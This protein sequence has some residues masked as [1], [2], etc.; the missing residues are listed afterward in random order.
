MLHAMTPFRRLLAAARALAVSGALLAFATGCPLDEG[1][2]ALSIDLEVAPAE[3]E[4]DPLFGGSPVLLSLTVSNDGGAPARLTRAEVVDRSGPAISLTVSPVANTVPARGSLEVRVTAL[5]PF[6]G[7]GLFT[8]SIALEFDDSITI[9]VPVVALVRVAPSCDDD[10]PCTE[11]SFDGTACRHVLSVDGTPCDDENACTTATFCFGGSCV[12]E[13]VRCTDGQ[14]CTVDAC[15]PTQGCV[16]EPMHERCD[17][18]DPCTDDVCASDTGCSNSPKAPGSLCFFGGCEEVGLC[19]N[20][21]CVMHDV[22]NGFPCSDGDACTIDDTCQEGVCAPGIAAEPGPEDPLVLVDGLVPAT[23]CAGACTTHHLEPKEVLAAHRR[24]DGTAQVVWR[25]PYVMSDTGLLCD[26]FAP[27]SLSARFI[28]PDEDDEGEGAAPVPC[29]CASDADCASGHCVGGETGCGG[30]EDDAAE[31]P[32]DPAPPSPPTCQAAIFLSRTMGQSVLTTQLET[33]RGPVAASLLDTNSIGTQVVVVTTAGPSS[34]KGTFYTGSGASLG[35]T[36]LERAMPSWGSAWPIGRLA[37]DH[38]PTRL[39]VVATPLYRDAWS[40]T[41]GCDDLGL[42]LGVPV[43]IW[44][45]SGLP[46]P[47]TGAPFTPDVAMLDEWPDPRCAI[48]VGGPRPLL[49]FDLQIALSSS[50]DD[51]AQVALRMDPFACG[52]FASNEILSEPRVYRFSSNVAELPPWLPSP[53]LPLE[54]GGLPWVLSVTQL[55]GTAASTA[56][57]AAIVTVDV[58]DPG[59]GAFDPGACDCLACDDCDCDCSAADPST[60]CTQHVVARVSTTGAVT[61][62]DILLSNLPS[63]DA[64]AHSVVVN[65]ERFVVARMGNVLSFLGRYDDGTLLYKP[66][67][68]LNDGARWRSGLVAGTSLIAGLAD[69]FSSTTGVVPVPILEDPIA[70]TTLLV[71]QG[72]ACGAVADTPP[73]FECTTTSDCPGGLVCDFSSCAC[74][75]ELACAAECTGVCL[76]PLPLPVGDAGVSDDA[77]EADGGTPDGGSET[78]CVDE[79]DCPA[80]HVCVFPEACVTDPICDALGPSC[81]CLGTCTPYGPPPPPNDDAGLGDLDAGAL[82]DAGPGDVDAGA[83]SVDAG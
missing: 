72:F 11:D 27:S 25:T 66:S 47:L 24:V 76:A 42:C 53:V 48:A 52:D 17:D 54:H 68:A 80:N 79:M 1:F 51:P 34:L 57:P 56:T 38:D 71:T 20:G 15:D 43:E 61:F 45:A 62:G 33:V 5:A 18:E 58:C 78:L 2:A 59:A 50:I 14:D 36:A 81:P 69:D 40:Q 19:V 3:I 9:T 21:S 74:S 31:P 10:N 49:V 55:D 73:P 65:D 41:Y 26:P 29:Q 32:D 13:P 37:V 67:P 22:P 44:H 8:S 63:S 6:D 28:P 16:Y 70:P 77:G 64:E 39:V 4:L 82:D 12:G 23:L 75:G 35:S 30:C 46:A 7:L 60:G 83:L